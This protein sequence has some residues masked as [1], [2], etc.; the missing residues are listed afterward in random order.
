MGWVRSISPD[1]RCRVGAWS[2]LPVSKV[3]AYWDDTTRTYRFP[4]GWPVGVEPAAYVR[5][6]IGQAGAAAGRSSP[7]TPTEGPVTPSVQRLRAI[8]GGKR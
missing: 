4:D 8:I 2:S 3:L 6:Q 5:A 1:Q 7:S